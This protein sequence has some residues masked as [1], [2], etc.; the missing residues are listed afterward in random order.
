MATKEEEERR[1]KSEKL[2]DGKEF[3]IK[4]ILNPEITHSKAGRVEGWLSKE[5][6]P[7]E[8]TIKDVVLF[9][10]V[11]GTLISSKVRS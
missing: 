8:G 7:V 10:D 6:Y 3:F 4:L 2:K 11:R 5:L 1:K 9:G